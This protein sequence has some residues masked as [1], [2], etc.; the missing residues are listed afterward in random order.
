SSGVW[1]LRIRDAARQNGS[2][3][4]GF[5][6]DCP[7]VGWGFCPGVTARRQFLIAK[8]SQSD[9]RLASLFGIGECDTKLLNLLIRNLWLCQRCLNR[10]TSIFAVFG[11]RNIQRV[12]TQPRLRVAL[13]FC[14][15]F[16]LTCK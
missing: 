2:H 12:F 9:K 8:P 3:I 4:E 5:R 11:A 7:S 10:F 1:G 15:G 13:H 16:T 14:E 6:Q